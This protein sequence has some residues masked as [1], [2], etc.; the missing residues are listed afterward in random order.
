MGA[1]MKLEISVSS[2]AGADVDLAGIEIQVA[3]NA[4]KLIG[5]TAKTGS[6]GKV[7]IE[8]TVDDGMFTVLVGEPPEATAWDGARSR[9][10][11]VASNSVQPA[12]AISFALVVAEEEESAAGAPEPVGAGEAVAVNSWGSAELVLG[13]AVGIGYWVI[14]LALPSSDEDGFGTAGKWVLGLSGA[15]IALGGAYLIT[16]WKT[17][18]LSGTARAERKAR[19]AG[20]PVAGAD[21]R[22]TMT[23]RF[24]LGFP[25]IVFGLTL[26]MLSFL[27]TNSISLGEG[28]RFALAV[29]GIAIAGLLVGLTRFDT[30]RAAASLVIVILFIGLATFPGARDLIGEEVAKSLIL[31]MG[32]VLGVNTVAEVTNQVTQQR[33]EARVATAQVEAGVPATTVAERSLHNVPGDLNR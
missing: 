1:T 15:A 24:A 22:P 19:K 9:A 11:G 27:S 5:K 4:G 2:P 21:D 18:P 29:G 26:T 31:W 3:D 30:I 33:G 7:T 17:G 28:R 8:E 20:T 32:I 12:S 23:K 14:M 25:L 6:D 13:L 10:I 16:L